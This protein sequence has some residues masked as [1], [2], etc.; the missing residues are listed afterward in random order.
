MENCC[1][2]NGVEL[3]LGTKGTGVAGMRFFFCYYLLQCHLLHGVLLVLASCRVASP[4]CLPQT[5]PCRLLVKLVVRSFTRPSVVGESNYVL[6]YDPKNRVIFI[7][8]KFRKRT[9]INSGGEV[10]GDGRGV[11]KGSSKG[12]SEKKN[13]RNEERVGVQTRD[14]DMTR[15]SYWR[16]C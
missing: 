8:F 10:G 11:V 4:R 9:A 15:I 2:D 5:Y 3:M 16:T 14:K 6:V 1:E 13:R 12:R 7:S